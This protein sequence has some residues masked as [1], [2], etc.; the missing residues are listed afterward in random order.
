M[1][2][3]L[4]AG[5]RCLLVGVAGGIGRAAAARFLAEGAR[6][7]LADEARTG[8]LAADELAGLGEVSAVACDATEV[9]QV[10]A[11]VTQAVARLGGLDVLYHLAGASGRRAGDGS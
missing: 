11:A 3:R 9:R 1:A 10:E 6:L 5:K 8:A 4:L 2:E 7:L